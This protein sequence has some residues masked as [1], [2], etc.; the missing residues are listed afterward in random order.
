V[1]GVCN[2]KKQLNIAAVLEW[3]I[4]FIFTFYAFSFFI[5]L[6]PAIHTKNYASN[7]T[8]MEMEQNDEVGAQ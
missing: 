3:A 1:F 2:F 8:T 4:A 7:A 5:D 6:V